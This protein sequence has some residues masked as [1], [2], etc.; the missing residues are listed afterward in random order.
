MIGN[1]YLAAVNPDPNHIATNVVIP[2]YKT[3]NDGSRVEIINNGQL[4]IR[5]YSKG[6]NPA[7]RLRATNYGNCVSCAIYLP[8]SIRCN[9]V[10][11]LVYQQLLVDNDIPSQLNA[12]NCTLEHASRRVKKF[13]EISIPLIFLLYYTVICDCRSTLITK[14]FVHFRNLD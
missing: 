12:K 9:S 1:G 5:L 2:Y 14:L 10:W 6:R 7:V 11:S 8:T 4:E 3:Y 13:V